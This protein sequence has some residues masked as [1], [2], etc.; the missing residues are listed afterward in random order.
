VLVD[1]AIDQGGCFETSRPTTHTDPTYVVD[2]VLH[3]CVANMPGAVP[4][5]STGA[6]TNVTLPYVEAIADKGVSRAIVEDPAL[7]KGVNVIDGKLT[8]EPVAEAVGMEY[9]ALDQVALPA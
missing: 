1:V 8:Y 6:L 4:I 9:T 7:A 5:T 2:D 3:Y